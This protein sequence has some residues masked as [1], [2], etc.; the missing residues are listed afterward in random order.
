MDLIRA[1]RPAVN[2]DARLE[3]YL[4]LIEQQ[5]DRDATLRSKQNYLEP[6]VR[7]L[8]KNGG[9]ATSQKIRMFLTATRKK[10]L[11]RTTYEKYGKAIVNFTNH[12]AES[13]ER[14]YLIKP[15]G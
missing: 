4:W 9:L 6:W 1:K 10:Q 15:V 2:W 12:W 3:H 7:W 5:K 13:F 11:A 8:N 14:V